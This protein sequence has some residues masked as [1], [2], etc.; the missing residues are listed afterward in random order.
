MWKYLYQLYA[1]TYLHQAFGE[2]LIM[3]YPLLLH[4]IS[5]CVNI[6]M[7]TFSANLLSLALVISVFVNGITQFPFMLGLVSLI[8]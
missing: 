2:S 6:L 7:M 5:L 8:L 1:E 3:L 4:W